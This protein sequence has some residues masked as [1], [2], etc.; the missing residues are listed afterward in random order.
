MCVCG[1]VHICGWSAETACRKKTP[2]G[3]SF[4]L[5]GPFALTNSLSLRRDP[6]AFASRFSLRYASATPRPRDAHTLSLSNSLPNSSVAESELEMC[7]DE[8]VPTLSIDLHFFSRR[9][10]PKVVFEVY[11]L[12]L[13][14]MI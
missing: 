12:A 9:Y 3:A 6:Y 14:P 11:F 1:C 4:P 13:T 10:F 2:R 5:L 8:N 7:R